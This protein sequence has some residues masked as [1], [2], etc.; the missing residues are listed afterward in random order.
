MKRIFLALLFI[1]LVFFSEAQTQKTRYFLIGY[2]VQIDGGHSVSN[3]IM[4]VYDFRKEAIVTAILK[5]HK[6]SNPTARNLVIIGMYE[7]K[8][9]A[10]MEAYLK[11]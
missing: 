2:S 4:T 5:E 6:K 8:N 9:K 10:E 7:F 1:V 11:K 3:F